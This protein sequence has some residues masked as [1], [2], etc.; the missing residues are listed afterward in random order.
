MEKERKDDIID[1][2]VQEGLVTVAPGQRSAC[3]WGGFNRGASVV[4]KV[5]HILTATCSLTK[6]ETKLGND[7]SLL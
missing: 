5:S 3:V 7:P 4:I 6:V 2:N 1:A